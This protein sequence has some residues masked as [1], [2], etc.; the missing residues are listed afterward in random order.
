MISPLF[1]LAVRAG[2]NCNTD[3]AV[4]DFPDPD[5]PTTA[6]ISPAWTV[7]EI[8]F[9]A[10]EFPSADRKESTKSLICS[11]GSNGEIKE[12]LLNYLF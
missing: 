11:N 8:P 12:I 10:G 7:R 9:N 4:T 3:K 2:N 5:S 6:S 1:T